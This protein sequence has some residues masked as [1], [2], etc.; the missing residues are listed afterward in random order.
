MAFNAGITGDSPRKGIYKGSG[1]SLTPIVLTGQSAPGTGAGTIGSG[2]TFS[3][4][5]DSGTAAFHSNIS[6]GTATEGIFKGSD[7]SLSNIAL[8]GQ[9]AGH[10]GWHLL[11]LPCSRDQRRWDGSLQCQRD[12]R[13]RNARHLQRLWREPN[14]H[15]P[16]GSKRPGTGAGTFIGL[17]EFC[18]LNDSET[19]AFSAGVTGGT[20]SEGI[21]KGS[22]G[23]LTN[24]ALQG[25][26]RHGAGGFLNFRTPAPNES[27]T[28]AFIANVSG[29]SATSGIFKGSGDTVINI[30]VQGQSAPG[31]GGEPSP[32]STIRH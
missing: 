8:K 25:Q 29:G 28:A 11:R 20:A 16:S 9:S 13:Q 31:T 6:G 4:P 26:P 10:G 14:Q 3:A 22:G 15:C 17:S 5:N 24:I 23:S 27:G 19:V 7:G 30:A 21:F 32:L 18:A 12:G 1:G 2:F